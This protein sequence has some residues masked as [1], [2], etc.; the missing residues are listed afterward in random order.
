MDKSRL[1]H[2]RASLRL[3]KEKL[4]CSNCDSQQLCFAT[5]RDPKTM[6]ALNAV[7]LSKGPYR[8]G[9]FIYKMEEQFKSLFIIQS[10]VIKLEKPLEDGNSHITGFYFPGDIIGLESAGDK[11]YRYDAI[12]LEQSWVC[13]V[14]YNFMDSQGESENLLKEQIIKLYGQKVRE[15]DNLLSYSRYQTSEQRLL[16]FLE[17][18]CKRHFSQNLSNTHKL[19]LPMSKGDIANYLGLRPESI[20]RAL[21]KL[22][23]QGVIRN[24]KNAIEILDMKVAKCFGDEQ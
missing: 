20:S 7:T 2:E 17:L 5:W 1:H 18:L 9:D 16:Q 15:A 6:H 4:E 19:Q 22:Q 23:K 24:H 11:K 21:Q 10:G 3:I 14:P 12:A 13:E 8:I